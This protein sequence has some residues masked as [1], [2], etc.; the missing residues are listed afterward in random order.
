MFHA[1]LTL[2]SRFTQFCIFIVFLITGIA[3]S[4]VNIGTPPFSSLGG[5]PFDTVNLGSLNTHFAIPVLQKAGRGLSFNYNL[6]YDSSIWQPITSGTTKS[7][8]PV[9]N[10]SWGWT[11]SMR[12]GGQAFAQSVSSTLELCVL[13]GI[14][15][16]Q[17]DTTY[18]GWTYFDA[19]GTPHVFPGFS[20]TETG[21]TN[22]TKGF[23]PSAARDGSGYQITVSGGTITLLTAPDGTIINAVP[24]SNTVTD[25]NGNKITAL[26]GTYTDTLGTQVL[27]VSGNGTPTSPVTY[28]YT[29]PGGT[30]PKVTAQYTSYTV[31]THF[32]FSTIH[33]YAPKANSLVSS[34]ELPDGSAY[35][36]TY[37]QTPAAAACM[38]LP[39]TFS[40]Y[41]ITGRIASVTLPTGGVVTYVYSGGT[42]GTGIFADGSTATLT[43]ILSN[44]TTCTV[45]STTAPCWQYTRGLVSGTPGP[46]ST[47]TTTV[48][49]PNG[50]DTVLNFSEDSGATSN[51][52]ETQRKSY[53]GNTSGT[54]LNTTIACYNANYTSCATATVSSPITEKDVYSQLPNGNTRLSQITYNSSGS[55]TDDKEYDYGVTMGAAPTT[56]HRIKETATGYAVLG[57]AITNKPS[58]ITIYDWT[59]GSAV[60]LSGT[61]YSYDGGTPTATTGTPQHGG[62]TGPRGNLTLIESSVGIALSREFTY[63]DTGTPNVVED[64]NGA[65]TTYIYG[66]GSCGNSFPTTINEPLG[67][68]RSMVWDCNGGINTQVTDENGKVQSSTYTDPNF[69]RPATIT[70]QMS[71][72]TDYSY[73]GQTAVETALQNFNSGQSASDHRST[74]DGFGRPILSQTL[75]GPNLSTYDTVETDYNNVGLVQRTTMPFSAAAGG[76]SLT[77]PDT[78][79]TYDALGR[80]LMTQDKDGGKVSFTYTNND[81]L[82]QVSGTQTFRKQFEYDGLGRLTS[83]C[84]ISTTLPGVGSCGQSVSQ[85]GYLTKYTYDAL[86]HLLT[87]TQNAQA[88][89]ASQQTRTFTYN[90]LGRLA[91]ESNPE[92]GNNGVN[93]T[94]TYT[95][96]SITPCADGN[97]YTSQGDLV[98]RKDNAGNATCYAYDAQ[99]RLLQA[100]NSTISGA[101]IRKFFYD[102]ENSYPTGVTIINGKTRPVE[103]QTL[104]TS[105]SVITD[106]FFSYDARGEL[107]DVY[108]ST[109][110]SGGFY[111]STASYWPTGALNMLAVP[112]LAPAFFYG[113]NGLDGPGL[114]P[115]GRVTRVAASSGVA[116]PFPSEA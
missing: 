103:A 64:I 32:G 45:N 48:A 13:R 116:D 23:G 62:V 80:V 29:G 51:L 24:G 88:V 71:N 52:Y 86:G 70:D 98:E 5:G 67:L 53:Q 39:N 63:Y 101:T 41:C 20:M 115:E 43:R 11:S 96:D 78:T 21:C 77:A 49:D 54:L 84:E 73:F 9:T 4:Q 81:V 47:W 26:N 36:F 42:N 60:A 61:A 3:Q 38:P 27:V 65:Q 106:E 15:K 31:A 91:T 25:A 19:F 50:N 28:Q 12:G 97:N 69:W 109:P 94:I 30:S 114:D 111:H 87:V 16:N 46:G 95:Y 92:T 85:T 104:T 33:E 89:P 68:S 110:H 93:G 59:S 113:Y 55:V 34:I 102:S 99:H 18:T 74:I 35:S 107:T 8:A 57:G 17:I 7:W 72:Q 82:Q 44:S 83:V 90:A 58:G 56:A 22:L 66:T 108:E 76:T 79:Q 75:Q 37:E 14:D 105:N 112:S 100:G 10:T 6:S 2:S 40:T 1:R